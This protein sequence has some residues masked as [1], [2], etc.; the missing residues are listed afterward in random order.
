MEPQAND[1]RGYGRDLPPVDVALHD[2][3]VAE[4]SALLDR[5]CP[6]RHD[7]DHVDEDLWPW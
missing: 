4:V 7:R 2:R 1:F 3:H 5:L 6:G